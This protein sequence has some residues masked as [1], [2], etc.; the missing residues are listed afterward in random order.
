M[1]LMAAC[2]A[3]YKF[4]YVDIGA[5]GSS[6]DSAVFRESSYGKALINGTLSLPEPA[7][8]PGTDTHFPFFFAADAAFPLHP[9]IMRPY[10]GSFLDERKNI[11]NMRLS[12]T[13]R[14]IENTFGILAQR[15]RRLRNP[16]IG[17]EETCEL[18]IMATVV[19]HN[20]LQ[21]GEEDMEPQERRYSPT[22]FVDWED[23]QGNLHPGKW[24]LDAG[25]D[26][27]SIGRVGAN[28]FSKNVRELRDCLADWLISPFGALHYQL[29]QLYKY[30]VPDYF[31]QNANNE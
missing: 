4:T 5:P 19:L 7:V 21:K 11:F 27:K 8:L 10:P 15:W 24:R 16:I 9:N 6:H 23:E 18:I 17:N 2:D 25:V 20:F 3:Y 1:I 12:R 22:G 28:N 13:R 30:G 14:S 31:R 29:D 26:L